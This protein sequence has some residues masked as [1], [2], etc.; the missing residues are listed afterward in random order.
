MR[1]P[2]IISNG[3]SKCFGSR[4]ELKTEVICE[5]R[6]CK[7]TDIIV[8]WS[9][10]CK[11][12]NVVLQDVLRMEWRSI[13]H[14]CLNSHRHQRESGPSECTIRVQKIDGAVI[15]FLVS[16]VIE[17]ICESLQITRRCSPFGSKPSCSCTRNRS[18]FHMHDQCVSCAAYFAGNWLCALEVIRGRFTA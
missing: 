10:M 7:G 3:Y 2:A 5:M 18:Y 15:F 4:R 8:C 6:S 9:N 1:G 13:S 16:N 12:P 11:K 17:C 14:Q